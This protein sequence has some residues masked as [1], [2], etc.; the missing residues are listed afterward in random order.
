MP[1]GHS[2]YSRKP[3]P[4]PSEQNS[5]GKQSAD[6]LQKR[7]LV[8]GQAKAVSAATDEFDTAEVWFER[9]QQD[10]AYVYPTAEQK[11]VYKRDTGPIPQQKA[12]D[13]GKIKY[14]TGQMPAVKPNKRKARRQSTKLVGA[15]GAAYSRKKGNFFGNLFYGLGF[16][17]EYYMC[18]LGRLLRDAGIF[19]AQV[20]SFLFGGLLGGIAGIAKGIWLDITSPFRR[21]KE[22]RK[23]AKEIAALRRKN[24]K[25]APK[26]AAVGAARNVAGLVVNV[27]KILFPIAGAVALVLTINTIFSKTYALE[28]RVNDQVIGYVEDESVLE[29][30]QNILR[31]KIQLAPNQSLEEWNFTPVLMIGATETMYNKN[32]I[33]DQILRNSDEVTEGSGLM[34]DGE[35]VLAATDGERLRGMLDEMKRPYEAQFPDATVGFMEN[36]EVEDGVFFTESL[37]TFADIESLLD[38]NVSDEITYT[39]AG[40]ETLSEIAYEGGISLEELKMRNPDLSGRGENYVPIEG[41]QILLRRAVPYL[42]VYVA[43][44]RMEE[45]HIPYET[46]EVTDD[47]LVAGTTRVTTEGVEGIHQVYYDYLI[48]D[49]EAQSKVLVDGMTQVIQEP[50][51]EVIAHGTLVIGESEGI[52]GFSGTYMWPVPDWTYSSRGFLSGGRHKGLDINGAVGTPIHASNAGTVVVST[53][54]W[55]YGYYVVIEHPDGLRTLYAHNTQL[56]VSVGDQ[57]GQYAV[58]AAMG[59]TGNSTGPHCHFE[60]LVNGVAVNPYDYVSPP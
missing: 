28:V 53:Y 50:V 20:F 33:A 44:R 2:N 31:M 5:A 55:S 27:V 11:A 30:A 56:Y 12:T 34:V 54:H 10:E 37:R 49:G 57:V 26:K 60:V 48:V 25:Q 9:T 58:I 43:E 13:T 15:S 51:T 39:A 3:T 4:K 16:Y 47:T 23:E 52:G 19:L 14:R 1:Y 35:L 45:E 59:S 17:A 32:E 18:R 22:N 7:K 29:D 38:S 42:R 21:F 6:P 40:E 46:I 36:V 24:P 41:T 8:T